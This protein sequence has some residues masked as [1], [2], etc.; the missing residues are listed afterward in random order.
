VALSRLAGFVALAIAI[1]VGLVFWVGSCQ[2]KSKHDEYR[3]YMDSIEPIA[4]SSA[5]SLRSYAKALESPKLTLVQLQS[6]LELWSRQQ[7]LDYTAAER[8]VPPAPLQAPH[9]QVL[10]T[11][12]LR[13]IGL[14]GLAD[15]LA[16][17]G[18]KPA[19]KVGNR[20]AG[21]AE[22]LTASDIVWA[23]LFRLPAKE[24][25]SRQGV[26][27]VIAPPSQIVTSPEV[28]TANSFARVYSRLKTTPTT[29]KVTGV[30]GS[31]LLGTEAVSGGQTKTLSASSPT[32]VNVA[33]DLVFKVS[34]KNSGSTQQVHIP[35]TLTVS[36]FKKQA[37]R[38]RKVVPSIL[39]GQTLTVNFAN[40][41]LPTS[42]FG[43][44]ATVSV[45][46]GKVPGEVRLDNNQASYPV[47]FS[48]PSGG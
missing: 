17:A 39:Q 25:L 16:T 36:V 34:F 45:N 41:Q 14:T 40:L 18:T 26:I 11:L 21:E 9:Q 42:V 10:A 48:L 43:A 22:L 12:Q 35:V 29:G 28:I 5:S 44:N 4:Q 30:H 3:S 1:V 33:A 37:L 38:K 6:M 47:F 27:G 15:T 20:L 2:G 31:E 24:T 46:I 23:N 19:S 13:A 8:L 7:Q 32:T